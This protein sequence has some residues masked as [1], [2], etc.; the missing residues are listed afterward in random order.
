MGRVTVVTGA[1]RGIG[2]SISRR[3]VGEGWIVAGC[4]MLEAELRSAADSLGEGFRPYPLDVT[5]E[6]AVGSTCEKMASELG[7]PFGLVNN[8]GITRDNLLMRMDSDSWDKV[9]RVNLTGAFLMTK[10]VSKAMMKQRQGSIVNISSVS[11]LMG[12]VGQA[13]YAAS[14]AGLLGLTR[15]LA[16]EFA[17]RNIRVNAVAPGFIETEM[18]RALT[19]EIRESYSARIPFA[20][21]GMPEDVAGAVSFLLSDSSSYVTGVVLPVDGGLST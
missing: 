7:T 20:R 10:A 6:Q 14:K 19:P 11:A 2:L 4:D 15:S 21:M 5:D 8:A 18:T 13:N 12:S 17:S 1:G 9:I 16:R 3:L